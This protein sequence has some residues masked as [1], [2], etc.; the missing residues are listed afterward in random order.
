MLRGGVRNKI[1]LG[2]GGLLSHLLIDKNKVEKKFNLGI[3]PHYADRDNEI[4]QKIQNANPNSVILDIKKPPKEF[5]YD[6]C[7]CKTVISSAMHPLIACDALNIP[8]LWVR[9]SEKTTS[10]YKFMDYYSVYSTKTPSP[11]YILDNQK[12]I[13]KDYIEKNYTINHNEVREIQK[14]L[15]NQMPK[16]I[17][18]CKTELL[19]YYVKK[20]LKRFLKRIKK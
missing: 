11:I 5:L 17:H 3:V 14:N 12:I 19:F 6:L 16:V 20:E 4:W 1:V 2:D 15:I 9:I 10:Y 18:S 8:N 7:S 13:N